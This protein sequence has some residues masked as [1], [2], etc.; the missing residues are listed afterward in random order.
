MASRPVERPGPPQ[1]RVQDASAPAPAAEPARG[2]DASIG[3][4]I[5]EISSDLS[6]LVRNE[7]ELAKTELKQEG[8]KAGKAA[9]LYGGA[10]YAAGLALLLGSFAAMYGLRHVMDIAWAALILTV[11]WA[12]VGAALYAAGR[13]RM[14]TVQLTPERSVESLKEDAKWARHPTG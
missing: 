13:R 5:S 1:G 3:D 14:R 7:V 6:R 8:R 10:G 12:A 2:D 9:G 11:V 4:L